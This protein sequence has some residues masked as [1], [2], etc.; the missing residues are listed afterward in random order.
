VLSDLCTAVGGDEPNETT[1]ADSL[2]AIAYAART[3]LVA[4]GFKRA[5]LD[6]TLRNERLKSAPHVDGLPGFISVGPYDRGRHLIAFNRLIFGSEIILKP[7]RPES[8]K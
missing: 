3:K 4:N 6:A 7:S 5:D 1:I 2:E 8:A